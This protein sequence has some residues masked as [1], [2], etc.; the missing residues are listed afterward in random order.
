MLTRVSEQALEFNAGFIREM[1]ETTQTNGAH[2][3]L[4]R[5]VLRDALEHELTP[6]QKQIILMRFYEQNSV[7]QIAERLRL[8]KSTVSRTLSRAKERLR[9]NLRVYF[10]YTNY[11]LSEERE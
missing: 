3:Q 8:D 11:C 10:D 4:A 1:T 5:R 9:R 7:G 6:R 2:L